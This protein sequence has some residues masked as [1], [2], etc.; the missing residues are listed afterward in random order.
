[1]M[2]LMVAPI[3]IG[4]RIGELRSENAVVI[5]ERRRANL[6]AGSDRQPAVPL[7]AF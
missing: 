2:K 1:M 6:L 7:A 4:D 3:V 5:H